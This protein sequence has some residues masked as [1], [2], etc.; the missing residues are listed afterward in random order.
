MPMELAT[1][2]MTTSLCSINNLIY[3]NLLKHIIMLYVI[4]IIHYNLMLDRSNYT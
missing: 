4:D 3:I 1:T 2:P